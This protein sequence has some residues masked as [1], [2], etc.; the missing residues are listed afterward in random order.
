MRGTWLGAGLMWLSV[1]SAGLAQSTTG[2]IVGTVMDPNGA[3]VGGADV[4]VVRSETG[5]SRHVG[6]NGQGDFTFQLLKPGTYDVNVAATGYESAHITGIILQVDRIARAD[7]FLKIGATTQ[8]VTV[9]ASALTLDTDS[10]QVGQTIVENQVT[11]LPMNGRN[12]TEPWAME[13]WKANSASHIPTA[14]TT[15]VARYTRP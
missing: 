10:A 8:S 14:P 15:T 9:N 1:A 6:T 13:M 3:L 2:T 5:E 12:F 11:E 7:V 4:T